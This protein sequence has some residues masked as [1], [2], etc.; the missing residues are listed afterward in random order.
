MTHPK[1]PRD[2]NQLAKSIIAVSL[3]K[4]PWTDEENER[5]RHEWR[6]NLSSRRDAKN[7]R[8]AVSAL[9]LARSVARSRPLER[10]A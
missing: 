5:L 4:T 9:R 6:I 8:R 1:R 7:A 10:C 2:P 3:R